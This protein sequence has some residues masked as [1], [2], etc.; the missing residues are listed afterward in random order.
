MKHRYLLCMKKM[1]NPFNMHNP[2]LSRAR[3]RDMFCELQPGLGDI[4]M[5]LVMCAHGVACARQS[6]SL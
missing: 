3:D 5:A 2:V 1:H 6:R 4:N